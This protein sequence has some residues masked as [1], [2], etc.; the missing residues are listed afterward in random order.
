V[1]ELLRAVADEAPGRPLIVSAR[2]VRT[3]GEV[4]AD[5]EAIAAG[6]AAR[7]LTRVGAVAPHAE[8]VVALFSAGAL[9]GVEVCVYPLGETPAELDRLAE[10]FDHDVV[11]VGQDGADAPRQRALPLSELRSSDATPLTTADATVMI[12]TTGTTGERRGA[13]H[14]WSRLAPASRSTAPDPDARWLLAYNL[15]QFAGIA[16]LTHVLAAGATLVQPVAAR[17]REGLDAL[18]EHRVTHASATPTFWR[19]VL[20][21]L[22]KDEP[23][24]ALRQITLGGEA[25]PDRL[26]D[27]LRLRFPDVRVSQI[28]AATEFGQTGSVRDGLPGLPSSVLDRGDDAPVQLRVVDGELHVRSRVGMLGYHG[29]APIDPDEWRPT[30][31]LVEVRGERLHFVGRTSDVINV[32]GVKVHPGPIERIVE[33]VPGV[34]AACAYGRA[35]PLT[36][37]IVALEVVGAPDIDRDEVDTAIRTACADLPPAARPRSIKFVDELVTKGQK[38]NRRIPA[39]AK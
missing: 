31:D 29:E 39:E 37:Q 35:N 16:I 4:L 7:R 30:G 38:M 34:L 15:S 2:G 1:I 12:L 3:Y 5:A 11:V 14:R 19:G 28:Y 18:H 6:L 22:G 32:G 21:E 36:G 23:G 17:S 26:L 10:R 27:E 20:R 13:I 33:T 8:D 25:A 9:A 24:L